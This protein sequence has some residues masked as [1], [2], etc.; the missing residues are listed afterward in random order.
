MAN[1]T[2]IFK[3]GNRKSTGNYRPISLTCIVCRVLESIIREQIIKHMWDQKLVCDKQS[4]FISGRLT[5]L[6][7]LVVLDKWTEILDWR[8]S[9]CYIS[10]FNESIQQSPTLEISTQNETIRY[11]WSL[12]IMDRR[13]K[14]SKRRP[15]G[16]VNGEES[17]WRNVTIGIPQ[18]S[19]LGPILLVLYINDLAKSI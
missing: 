15:R 4:G 13:C 14:L 3:K 11:R 5:V 16:I 12:H 6:Q 18:G 10:W 8:L 17:E 1:I 19:I 2:A 7:L 9:R